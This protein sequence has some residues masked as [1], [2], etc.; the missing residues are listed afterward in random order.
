[1]SSRRLAGFVGGLAVLVLTGCASVPDLRFVPDDAGSRAD[2]SDGAPRD[3]GRD[4]SGQCT[5]AS[6]DPG[7]VCCGPVW[8]VGECAG[9]NCDDCALKGC[10]SGEVCCGKSGNV[11]CK[12]RCP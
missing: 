11:L 12:S 6:P 7:A 1:M 3:S 4:A 5:G 8:C 9:S 10:A 2:A